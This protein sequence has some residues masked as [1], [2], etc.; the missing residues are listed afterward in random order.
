MLI[1]VIIP[2]FNVE[3]YLRE[4]LNSVLNQT[5]K[6]YEVLLID[7]GSTDNSGALCDEYERK[8]SNFHVIHK[9]NEGLGL[10]RNTGLTYAKGEYVAFLDSD[11]YWSNDMLQTMY[12]TVTKCKV[13]MCKSGFTRIINNHKIVKEISYNNQIF[14]GG[15]ARLELLPLMIGSQPSCSDSV[16]VAVCACLYRMEIIK[17]FGVRFPSEKDLISEDL[18]FNINYM[19]HSQGAALLSY[20]GYFYRVNQESLTTKYRK[21]RFEA[22][23]KLYLYVHDLLNEYAYT[24]D[25]FVRL[26]RLFFVYLRMCINQE[27]KKISGLRFKIRQSELKEI[28][29][30]PLVLNC[31]QEYPVK[32]L[33]F[34]QKVFLFLIKKKMVVI[35]DLLNEG[36]M[37]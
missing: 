27:K 25:V 2:V 15:R 26:D 4:C 31:I 34:K 32:C 5:Y 10:A 23:K 37:I 7:D 19:Q 1:S 28:C 20:T 13:D 16:E 11:D 17:R 3:N 36:G 12:D 24:S 18:I 8:Y 21:D 30:D 29:D 35:I 14:D 33:G 22:S 6:E 9:K